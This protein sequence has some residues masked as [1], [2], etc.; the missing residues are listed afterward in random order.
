MILAGLRAGERPH[1]LQWLGLFIAFGGLAGL[2]TPGLTA[3]APAGA[4]LMALAGAA[5]GIYSL[6]GRGA[7]DPVPMTADNFLRTVPLTVLVSLALLADAQASGTGVLLAVLSGAVTSGIGYAIW[8]T[9]LPALSATRAATVQLSAPVL[10]A[11]GGVV[12]LSEPVT[13]RLVSSTV[14]I[15]GGVGLTVAVKERLRRHSQD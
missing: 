10:A 1:A 14:L 4:A 3:P 11:I 5:W 12:L 7:A 8:Y 2:L 13:L 15:L 6:H 9:V